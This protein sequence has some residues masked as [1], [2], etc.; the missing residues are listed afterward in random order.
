VGGMSIDRK[1][2]EKMKFPPCMAACPAS[3]WA[4]DYINAI[5]R[6]DFAEALRIEVR[7]NPFAAVCGRICTRTCEIYCTRGRVDEPVAIRA[8]KRFIAD[9][10]SRHNEL[11][12]EGVEGATTYRV[13][14]YDLLNPPLLKH[15]IYFL[16]VISEG[17]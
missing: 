3:V 11:G 15:L 10:A 17:I 4:R 7:D 13:M 16:S 8:L 1:V 14:Y 12:V 2:L 6:G 5:E 9:W